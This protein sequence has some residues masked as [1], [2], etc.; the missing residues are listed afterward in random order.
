MPP[1]AEG[2]R[3]A[4]FAGM[5]G[6]RWSWLRGDLVAGAHR[7]GRARPRVARRPFGHSIGQTRDVLRRAGEDS[8]VLERIYPSVEDAAAGPTDDEPHDA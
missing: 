8:G 5:A 6:Y 4:L 7:V 3:P 1:A 2:G